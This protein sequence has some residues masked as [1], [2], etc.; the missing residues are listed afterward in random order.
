M[1]THASSMSIHVHVPHATQQELS[2]QRAGPN[3]LVYMYIYN[4][5]III[6]NYTYLPQLRKKRWRLTTCRNHYVSTSKT[7][8][9]P[10]CP[11]KAQGLYI[12]T[13][14]NC[15]YEFR[16]I[17]SGNRD[18][19]MWEIQATVCCCVSHGKEATWFFQA[20]HPTLQ[21]PVLYCT[22]LNEAYYTYI[23]PGFYFIVGRMGTDVCLV[24]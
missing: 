7:P 4:I 22:S 21:A 18:C 24:S 20:P 14:H 3:C 23:S 5:Y 19:F 8:L 15:C 17:Q 10:L 1:R 6:H 9:P 16:W 12:N 13:R 2:C 11:L